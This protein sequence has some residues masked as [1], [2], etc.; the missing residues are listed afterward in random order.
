MGT[1]KGYKQLTIHIPDNVWKEL[2][3]KAIEDDKT[4]TDIIIDLLKGYLKIK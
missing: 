4:K 2:S 1:K 3:H